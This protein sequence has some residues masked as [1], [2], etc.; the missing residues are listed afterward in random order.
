MQSTRA[1][2]KVNP[3]ELPPP[4]PNGRMISEELQTLASAM[5][6]VI[7]NIVTQR[8][9]NETIVKRLLSIE[10]KSDGPAQIPGP[11]N[12]PLPMYLG[13]SLAMCRVLNTFPM[14]VN[15][16]DTLITPSL[17][18]HGMWEPVVTR[19][20]MQSLKP[21]MTVVDIGAN[22]GYYTLLAAASAGPSGRVIAF[23]PE[24]K[25]LDIL[26]RNVQ[27]NSMEGRV[28]IFPCA[29]ADA[30]GKA[31]LYMSPWNSGMHS[32]Y[33]TKQD[34]APLSHITVETVALDDVIDGPIDFIKI[35]AEGSEPPIFKGMQKVLSRSPAV[36]IL[37]EFNPGTLQS[38]GVNPAEF[39]KR[40]GEMGFQRRVLA[41]EGVLEEV[42]LDKLVSQE[43]T[44]LYLTR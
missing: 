12:D 42:Q 26:T 10:R 25:N 35:D 8:Q 13:D 17:L 28:K 18:L 1:V 3:Q 4:N 5:E 39:Y 21:G 2:A 7:Q 34:R 11:S 16:R 30:H 27:L 20:F 9:I 19:L 6:K 33:P 32:I 24:P 36:K 44:A 14:Y 29:V 40:L 37:M 23:E 38:A 15:A 31:E 41:K 22:Y 43:L